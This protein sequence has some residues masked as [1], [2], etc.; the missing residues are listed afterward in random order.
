MFAVTISPFCSACKRSTPPYIV[1][2]AE[3]WESALQGL[4]WHGRMEVRACCASFFRL[5]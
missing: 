5:L 2:I 1:S 3:L 4:A